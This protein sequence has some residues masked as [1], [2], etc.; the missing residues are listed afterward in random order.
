VIDM[1]PKNYRLRLPEMRQ[2]RTKPTGAWATGL[3]S[4]ALTRHH[5]SPERVAQIIR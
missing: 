1:P 3:G 2:N 5:L 4:P